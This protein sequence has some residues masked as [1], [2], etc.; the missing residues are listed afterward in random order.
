MSLADPQVITVNAV[1]KSMP[2]ISTTTSSNQRQSS[3]SLADKT[4]SLDVIHRDL[5]RNSRPRLVSLVRFTQRAN[6]TD[7]LNSALIP[8]TVAWSVQL[9]RPVDGFTQTQVD[10]MWTGFKSWFD[11]T[12]VGKIFG[13]ES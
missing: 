7:P 9:D 1:A 13:G 6:V 8:E 12:M 3:Y 5:K 10:Q 4:F 11:S 2:R